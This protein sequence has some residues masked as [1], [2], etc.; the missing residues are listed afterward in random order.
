MKQKSLGRTAG[1][2]FGYVQ[3]FRDAPNE[4]R[5]SPSDL[6]S[7]L[8]RMIDEFGRDPIAKSLAPEEFEAARFALV[9]WID[10]T[11]VRSNWPGRSD[12][13]EDLLQTRLFGTSRAG[14]EF[15]VRLDALRPE[16]IHA[17]EIFFLCLALGFEGQMVG[18]EGARSELLRQQYEKLRASGLAIDAAAP[19]HLA[20]PAYETSIEVHGGAGRRLWPI[21]TTWFV[22]TLAACG[23]LFLALWIWAGAVPTPP[24]T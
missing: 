20:E 8:T 15:Y 24:G 4:V 2:L 6:R 17:R 7:H 9:A 18:N 21:L 3:L 16:M 22:A 5:P 14:N 19:Q 11:V 23:L 13:V 12:W 10:E 1:D